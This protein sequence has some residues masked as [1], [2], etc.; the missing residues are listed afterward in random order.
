MFPPRSVSVSERGERSE[1]SYAVESKR[2]E[3]TLA[4]G[5]SE[6]SEGKI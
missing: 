5:K 6:A 2:H 4:G 3:E 1:A